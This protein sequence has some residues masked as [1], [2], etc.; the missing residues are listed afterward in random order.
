MNTNQDY[1]ALI[2]AELEYLED[3][4]LNGPNKYVKQTTSDYDKEELDDEMKIMVTNQDRATS[5]PP[6]VCRSWRQCLDP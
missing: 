4:T 1:I 3:I 5:A 2:K 6:V